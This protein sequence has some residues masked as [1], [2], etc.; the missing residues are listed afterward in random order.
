MNLAGACGT[1]NAL[2]AVSAER[3]TRAPVAN[4]KQKGTNMSKHKTCA[5]GN[6]VAHFRNNVGVCQRCADI[7]ANMDGY[8][9][10]TCG[11]KPK[12]RQE[13]R[14]PFYQHWELHRGLFAMHL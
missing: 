1:I 14:E 3:R 7:E 4:N 5:C 10:M 11:M 12:G 6:P 13:S 2:P 9:R 8:H